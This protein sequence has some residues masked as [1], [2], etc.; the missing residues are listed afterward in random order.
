[1]IRTLLEHIG[2]HGA[3]VYWERARST[4][5]HTRAPVLVSYIHPHGEGIV[6]MKL[7]LEI[8]SS[9]KF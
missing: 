6:V 2:A 9:T 1:M 7:D 4:A 5:T 8:D 3:G